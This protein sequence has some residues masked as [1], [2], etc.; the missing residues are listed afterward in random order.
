MRGEAVGDCREL[1]SEVSQL[2]S[3][4]DIIR[5][6]KSRRVRWVRHRH[7]V[8]M[9]GTRHGF[10]ILVEKLEGSGHFAD[11]GIDGNNIKIDVNY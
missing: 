8:Q 6:I 9:G 2:F 10:K 7:G 11:I 5:A 4:P 3:S 1:H